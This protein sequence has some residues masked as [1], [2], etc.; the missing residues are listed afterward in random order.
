MLVFKGIHIYNQYGLLATAMY[1]RNVENGEIEITALGASNDSLDA[2]I[3]AA[4]KSKFINCRF[5]DTLEIKDYQLEDFKSNY[6]GNEKISF[7]LL[8]IEKKVNA[9]DL[10]IRLNEDNPEAKN[11]K[12]LTIEYKSPKKITERQMNTIKVL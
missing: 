11:V 5:Y 2:A 1:L 12:H 10:I 6:L 9:V 7:K 8:L 3:I 4:I